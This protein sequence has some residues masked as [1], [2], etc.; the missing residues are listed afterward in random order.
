MPA[1]R[2]ALPI[3]LTA[4]TA[5]SLTALAA[6][7]TL[8]GCRAPDPAAAPPP[9]PPIAIIDGE[10][11]TRS[12][13]VDALMQGQ[14]DAFFPR[15][16]ERH[17]VERE[18]AR[19]AITVDQGEIDAAV[20]DEERRVVQGRFRGDE[21]TFAEQ[22]ESYGLTRDDWRQSIA[23]KFRIRRLVEQLLKAA[24]DEDRIRAL[25]EVRYG[26]GGVRRKVSHLLVSTVPAASRAYTRAEYEQEKDAIDAQARYRAAELR[27][28]LAEGADFAALAREHSDDPSAKDGGDLGAMWSGRFGKA[29]DDA[30]TALGVGEISPVIEAR[31]G[32]H[33]AQVTGVRKGAVYEGHA[34]RVDAAP[35]APS[36]DGPDEAARMAAALDRAKAAHARLANGED[37]AVVA[38]EYNDDPNAHAGALGRFAPGR[39]GEAVDPVLE[40][41]PIGQ[42]SEPV[43]TDTGYVIAK[44]DART[45]LPAQDKKLVRDITVATDFAR[46]KVRKLRDTLPA[47]ARARAEALLAEA[48]GGADFAALAREHSEDE[49]TRRQGGA[50]P[51]FK[52]GT[53]GEAVDRALAEMK[54]GELR[55]IETDSGYH[56]VRLDAVVE[57]DYAKVRDDLEQELA[58]RPVKPEDV[59]TYLRTLRE[60]ANVEKKF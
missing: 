23:A 25:F 51:R 24:I 11:I 55:L 35:P 16:V 34:I 19:R 6:L 15:F 27:S 12:V 5:L 17:L 3:A 22:L 52:A 1:P 60:K 49:L 8:P 54:P 31:Q 4:L 20:A 58:Q 38:R 18:A 41:L 59:D 10:T 36:G 13:Y 45:F 39:L 28:R 46:V 56:L 32:Y 21:E 47:L 43:R 26:E 40:T 30:I 44:L 48:R 33:I 2:P 29:Y 7:A 53:L 37:F 9:D 42:I 14:G 57:S 50:L